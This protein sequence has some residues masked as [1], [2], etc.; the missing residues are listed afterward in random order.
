MADS[1][2]DTPLPSQECAPRHDTAHAHPYRPEPTWALAQLPRRA[3][4]QP[5]RPF[6]LLV[7]LGLVA[8]ADFAFVRP[9]GIGPGG[10]GLAA[11]FLLVPALVVVAARKKRLSLRLVVLAAMLIAVAARSAYAASAATTL[12]GLCTV[13]ALTTFLRAR[14]AFLTDVAR[15]FVGTFVT[16]PQRLMAAGEGVRRSLAGAGRDGRT[17]STSLA[18]VAVPVPRTTTVCGPKFAVSRE[19]CGESRYREVA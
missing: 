9:N 5:A 1:S 17:P 14:E 18:Q 8:A 2:L 10:F 3:G 19:L 11:F 4:T 13:F 16:F 12:F 7:A 6:E 15:S